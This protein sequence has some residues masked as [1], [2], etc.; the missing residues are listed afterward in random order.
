MKRLVLLSAFAL[1]ALTTAF[2]QA[3]PSPVYWVVE[4]NPKH[5]NYSIVRFYDAG[6]AL[7]HEVT[8]D[9]AYINI[10]KAKYRK[11]LDQ[12]LK[13]YNDRDAVASKKNRSRR[14]I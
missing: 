12:L 10:K 1:L 2:A 11:K 13:Q 9:G 3:S 14:S 7:V 8:I 4:T 5:T 6:N